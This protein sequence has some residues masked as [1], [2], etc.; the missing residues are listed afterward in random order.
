MIRQIQ[1]RPLGSVAIP[2]FL[3][4]DASGTISSY[5]NLG[6]M[7]RD[8]YAIADS[9]MESDT[10]ESL[11][12]KSRR[13]YAAIKSLVPEGR[14]LVG[15]WSLGGMIALQVAWIFARDP[16][17]KVDGIIMVDSPF[18]DYRHV[19]YIGPESLISE[20]GPTPVTNKFEESI[21]RSVNM[22]HNWRPPVW[23]REG[24]PYTAMLCATE[25][26]I[27]EDYPALSFIDQFRNSP[28]LGWD[29]RASSVVI[30]NS[31]PIQGH[32]FNVFELKNVASVTETIAT[33]AVNIERLA[34]Q[35]DYE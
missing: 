21:L 3:F 5:Y 20:D 2:L 12:E 24:Q 34:Y 10:Y 6:L 17:V 32:H 18:P 25:R 1:K 33:L 26:V 13:H 29:E 4:H 28:T 16:K 7:G 14:I 22:L 27:N 9:R 19:V 15:G 23:R 31:Y 8:V 30:D 11:Q 35:D